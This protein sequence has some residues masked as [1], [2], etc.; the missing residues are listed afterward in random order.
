MQG[1]N[2]MLSNFD[3]L[4]FFLKS[5]VLY[6]YYNFLFF[7]LN[8]ILM[9]L[10]AINTRTTTAYADYENSQPGGST[11]SAQTKFQS[12]TDY[13]LLQPIIKPNAEITIIGEDSG[14]LRE[15]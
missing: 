5:F 6:F 3:K 2:A 1:G 14:W 8:S 9:S 15:L 7:S 10:S 13:S 12:S 11:I 4:H